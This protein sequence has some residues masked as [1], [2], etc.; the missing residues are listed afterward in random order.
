LRQRGTSFSGFFQPAIWETAG[1]LICYDLV[2]PE[3][4]LCLALAGADIIFFPTMG[5]AAIE[6]T[7]SA[8]RHCVFAPR[9]TYLAAWS[10]NAATAP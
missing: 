9:K 6:T 1:L 8:C 2:V 5:G 7:T 4:A 10:L 3:T